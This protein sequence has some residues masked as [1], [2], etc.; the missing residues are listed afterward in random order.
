MRTVVLIKFISTYCSVNKVFGK[1]TLS[2]YHPPMED[3][4]DLEFNLIQKKVSS[5]IATSQQ[6]RPRRVGTEEGASLISIQHTTHLRRQ[7][8]VW[9]VSVES[10]NQVP[11]TWIIKLP[12]LNFI[13]WRIGI[14][15][16]W[17]QK[18]SE[19]ETGGGA[20]NYSRKVLLHQSS[21]LPMLSKMGP[22]CHGPKFALS[23]SLLLPL[24]I[25]LS[26]GGKR[27]CGNSFTHQNYSVFLVTLLCPWQVGVN[28]SRLNPYSYKSLSSSRVIRN[29]MEESSSF[30]SHC[31]WL[32]KLQSMGISG[33]VCC[34]TGSL[35]NNL[36]NPAPSHRRLNKLPLYN[37]TKWS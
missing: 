1:R 19:T 13:I 6:S 8:F 10:R 37:R 4:S 27:K 12:L 22:V 9:A 2:P 11:N 3:D 25:H 29:T 33:I 36:A 26:H 17:L 24:L 31:C 7:R 32:D 16:D 21:P 28:Y 23:L 35:Y 34:W 20:G 18:C 14:G 15:L 30:S 5:Q